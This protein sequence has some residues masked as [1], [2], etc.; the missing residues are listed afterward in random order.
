M[1]TKGLGLEQRLLC[2]VGRLIRAE[3]ELVQASPSDGR[4]AGCRKVWCPWGWEQ[5]VSVLPRQQPEQSCLLPRQVPVIPFN[6][7]AEL[8]TCPSTQMASE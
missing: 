3:G 8:I 7:H 2:N 4:L 6:L 5:K 1:E